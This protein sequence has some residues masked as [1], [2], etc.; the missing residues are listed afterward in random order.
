MIV[1]RRAAT[2]S[3]DFDAWAS[4]ATTALQAYA[5]GA[6]PRRPRAT[7]SIAPRR[8][9]RMRRR[10]RSLRSRSRGRGSRRSGTT[11]VEVG[12]EPPRRPAPSS[13]KP[14]RWR[15]SPS[16]STVVRRV[17][18]PVALRR[19]AERSHSGRAPRDCR[20]EVH[21]ARHRLSSRN[22][23]ARAGVSSPGRPRRR[24]RHVVPEVSRA[25]RDALHL[26]GQVVLARRVDEGDDHRPAAQRGLRP[27][28]AGPGGQRE[29]RQ[30]GARWPQ[31]APQ[32]VVA[33]ASSRAW[34]AYAEHAPLR[35]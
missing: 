11:A 29:V 31:R 13:G 5:A 18:A 17:L 6:R 26:S 32:P 2:W 24:S 20:A 16:T 22:A 3:A 34:P 35:R 15:P 21:P 10:T 7:P 27:R 8:T 14:I 23:C 9:A 28:L 30:P 4:G 19:D 33:G 12:R 25:R 1:L